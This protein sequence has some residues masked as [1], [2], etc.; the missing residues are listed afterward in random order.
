[1]NCYGKETREM[2]VRKYEIHPVAY[3]KLLSGQKKFSCTG[4]LLTDSYY[5][6]Q[7]IKKDNSEKYGTFFCG[8]PTAKHFLT[9]TAN[10]EL[11]LFNPLNSGIRSSKTSS[12][13]SKNSNEQQKP[14][15]PIT[16][17]LLN[18]IN[19][20]IVAWNTI[21]YGRLAQIKEAKNKYY[22]RPPFENEIS[23]VNKVISY[24]KDKRTLT[25][26]LEEL[27]QLNNLKQ[28][29]FSLLNKALDNLGEKS[30]FGH[31]KIHD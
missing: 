4:R 1:M 31:P 19:L 22:Y 11:T 27:S 8:L 7:Y 26:I 15:N 16:R 28:Y 13:S 9:L 21:P 2:L 29:D 17:E 10:A 14:I 6:F 18:A 23:Y 3:V 30:F 12:S 5:C 25:E 24:D 20:L